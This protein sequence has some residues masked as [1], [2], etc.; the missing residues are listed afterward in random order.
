[1]VSAQCLAELG[2]KDFVFQLALC[3]TS[4][5][6]G[7]GKSVV[8]NSLI[9]HPVL[10]LT[11]LEVREPGKQYERTKSGEGLLWFPLLAQC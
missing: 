4:P 2:G 9:G 6:E 3:M 5:M 10:M 8:L 11:L 1:M 7:A